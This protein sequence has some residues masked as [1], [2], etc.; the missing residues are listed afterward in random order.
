[1]ESTLPPLLWLFSSEKMC[2][3]YYV[4][5][6]AILINYSVSWHIDTLTYNPFDLKSPCTKFIF[7]AKLL[8][9]YTLPKTYSKMGLH[10]QM[11]LFI[12]LNADNNR[13][14]WVQ[15]MNIRFLLQAGGLIS[16][17][18]KVIRG[19]ENVQRAVKGISKVKSRD[20]LLCF[21]NSFRV[22]QTKSFAVVQE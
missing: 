20:T 1:M 7:C 22:S 11:L 2:S 13:A 19:G 21:F 18:K 16:F 8:S 4:V 15:C 14:T 3:A 17:N 12:L 9:I 10:T 5:P 6:K